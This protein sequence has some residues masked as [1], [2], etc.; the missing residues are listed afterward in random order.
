DTV[1][2]LPRHLIR[3]LAETASKQ[4]V[5]ASPYW[6][7]EWVGLGPYRITQWLQ[8]S[9]IEAAAFDQYYLGRPNIDRVSVRFFGDSNVLIVSGIGGDVE[10]VPVGSF[11]VEEAHTLRAQWE[12]VGSG[13]VILSHTRLRL[14]DWQYRD[15]SAPW[16]Q[17]PR[18]RLA[19]V[20]L[21]DRSAMVDT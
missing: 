4:V 12:A 20:K 6:T 11:K 17:D 13:S 19:L 14:G 15:P 16:A 8:G 18:V 3:P 1:V 2:P 21:I 5:A 7:T 9:F 10:V